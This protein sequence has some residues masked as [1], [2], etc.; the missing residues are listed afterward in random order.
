MTA[1]E[2]L[3]KIESIRANGAFFGIRC[4]DEIHQIG[5]ELECSYDSNTEEQLE[6]TC[7]TGFGHLWFDGEQDDLDEIEKALEINQM[8]EG[9]HR[10]LVYGRYGTEYG[11]DEQEVILTGAEV[12][13]VIE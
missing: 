5:E 12:V 2:I 10:Y 8:Y 1:Q 6:G 13:A 9:E 3:N 7:A 4:T 11:E